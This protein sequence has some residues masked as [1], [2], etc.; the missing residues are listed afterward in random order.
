MD[1]FRSPD[2][3]RSL[4]LRNPSIVCGLLPP[5]RMEKR[6]RDRGAPKE[7]AY[8]VEI[9]VFRRGIDK[10][11]TGAILLVSL[12]CRPAVQSPLSADE[13]WVRVTPPL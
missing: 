13:Q 4:F 3:L 2:Q 11:A 5:L 9:P 8:L 10:Q 6:R 7:N 1:V 12:F